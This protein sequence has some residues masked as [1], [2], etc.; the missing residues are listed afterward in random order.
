M[1]SYK[2]K[3]SSDNQ[4][5]FNLHAANGEIILTSERY[6]AKTSALAG[7]ESVRTNA[8]LD[9]RYS[10]LTSTDGQPYFTLHGRNGEVIGRSERYSSEQ[11]R[12]VGITSVKTNGPTSGTVDET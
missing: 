5:M 1:G 2:I 12:E 11:A 3:K 9:A 8:P 7:I 4:Y 6:T 10:R